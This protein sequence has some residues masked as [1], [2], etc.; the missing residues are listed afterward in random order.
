MT[1]AQLRVLVAL[2]ELGRFTDVAE[3]LGI[4]QSAVS[5]SLAGLEGELGISL[6]YR[7]R[8]GGV[9]T[10]AGKRVL[11]HAK[12]VI[13]RMDRI[14]EEVSAL[15]GL[16]VGTVRAG[17]LQ[18]VAARL[19]PGIVAR[20]RKKYPGIEVSVFEGTDPEIFDW[21]RSD[22]VDVGI[23]TSH[24]EGMETRFL[25]TDRLM[26]VLPESHPLAEKA[27][28]TIKELSKWP[29]IRSFVHTCGILVASGLVDL[30]ID[31]GLKM[32][33]A[34]NLETLGAMVRAGAGA[35][36]LPELAVPRDRSGIRVVPIVPALVRELVLVAPSFDGLSPAGK[37]FVDEVRSWVGNREDPVKRLT[38][39]SPA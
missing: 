15:S 14:R 36:I 2:E 33:E 17:S 22:T 32:I 16:T 3:K 7:D 13:A 34:R 30:G 19:L 21:M 26:A 37:V 31:P 20:F 28:I 23:V 11:I 39:R 29:L 10:E 5:H 4:T 1:I 24:A 6:V 27:E 35:G 12:E 25:M 18:S 8:R 9:P 38:E